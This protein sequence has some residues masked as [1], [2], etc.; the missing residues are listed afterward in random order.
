[1]PP[2]K[3]EKIDQNCCY[4]C[5][6]RRQG[7]LAPI[8]LTDALGCKLCQQIFVVKP[9]GYTLEQLVSY[10][11]RQ[12]WRWNGKQWQL[13]RRPLFPLYWLIVSSVIALILIFLAYVIGNGFNLNTHLLLWLLAMLVFST[14]AFM[15]QALF[16]SRR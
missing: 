9:D 4:P 16:S 15:L 7:E 5:P 10:P 8:T 6:C 2:S 14:I 11:Y 1:V 3:A 12:T 13:S